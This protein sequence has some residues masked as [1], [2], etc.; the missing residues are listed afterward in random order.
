MTS[1]PNDTSTEMSIYDI[2]ADLSH[3]QNKLGLDG[4][5]PLLKYESEARAHLEALMQQYAQK[6]AETVIGEDEMIETMDADWALV[7]TS[8]QMNGAKPYHFKQ[9]RNLHRE[10]QRQRN[11]EMKG[12]M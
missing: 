9:A 4:K 7:E 10:Y 3:K 6:Y 5:V 8:L 2:L 12:E 11:Q 1:Q